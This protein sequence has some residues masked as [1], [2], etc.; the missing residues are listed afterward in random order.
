MPLNETQSQQVQRANV[1]LAMKMRLELKFKNELN[2]MFRRIG[3]DLSV[4][5]ST[6]GGVISAGSYAND[7]RVILDRNYR[8]VQRIFMN[9]IVSFLKQNRT[10]LN[11]DLIRDL[12]LI[13]NARGSTV[14]KL[15]SEL[16]RNVREDLAVFRQFNIGQSVEQ[17][18]NTTQKE[19]DRA[20]RKA[21][22]ELINEFGEDFTNGQLARNS[23]T[24]FINRQTARAEMIAATEVQ[25]VAEGTKQLERDR[26]LG[27]RNSLVSTQ[28]NLEPLGE[29]EIW[30]TQ[31]DN[32]VRDG[33]NT[34]FNHLAADGQEKVN[35]TFTVSN[36][37]LRFPG[38]RSLGAS[39]G[40]VARCRCAAVTVIN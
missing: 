29:N 15:I 35:G 7:F 20:V 39:I 23:R 33:D 28:L 36:E 1:E 26:L 9:E 14:N 22:E 38:D 24:N 27:I 17:I 19:I 25:N 6:R 31:G 34:R 21:T 3:S 8:R 13:A 4:M 2:R 16:R 32:L 30:V 10:N 37:L 12:T 40:N 18:I 5:L 11:E